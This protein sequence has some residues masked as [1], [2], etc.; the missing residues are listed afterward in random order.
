MDIA[1]KFVISLLS[2]FPLWV[3]L[4][5]FRVVLDR[6]WHRK[7]EE[8]KKETRAAVWPRFTTKFTRL[9]DCGLTKH[10]SD[11]AM[12]ESEELG[13]RA[14][15]VQILAQSPLFAHHNTLLNSLFAPP[16][17]CHPLNI[18]LSQQVPIPN[19]LDLESLAAA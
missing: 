14:F 2:I 17:L 12:F 4:G 6:C 13:L 5:L 3:S 9:F 1:D 16:S 15:S 7:E 10:V 18:N 19:P 8:K 11:V